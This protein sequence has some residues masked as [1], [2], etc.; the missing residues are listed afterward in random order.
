MAY[1]EIPSSLV[2]VGKAIKKELFRLIR[3]NQIDINNRVTTLSLGANPIDV[4]EAD[5]DIKST[6]IGDGTFATYKAKSFFNIS[7]A[8][9]QIK[10][11][12]GNTGILTIDI[13]KATTLDGAYSSI[14]V[15]PMFIN[16]SVASDY[17]FTTGDFGVLTGVN[18]GE[19]LK[20]KITTLP[21]SIPISFRMSMH[22]G[23]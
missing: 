14:L 1:T 2:Q 18:S 19:Y 13:L 15:S 16:Y 17:D 10:S 8:I 7:A 3:E 9:L 6:V 20:M 12:A 11:V 21:N 4:I 22:G 5:V 23:V